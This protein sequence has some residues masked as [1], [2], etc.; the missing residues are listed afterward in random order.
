MTTKTTT[1]PNAAD[2]L[3]E[4]LTLAVIDAIEADPM[5]WS[6]TWTTQIGADGLPYNATTGTA[7]RGGNVLWLLVTAADR[8]YGSNAWATYKQWKAAGAQ[9]RRGEKATGC[10]FWKR[11]EREDPDTGE[12]RATMFARTFSVFNLARVEV[13]DPDAFAKRAKIAAAIDPDEIGPDSASAI[14]AWLAAVPA[15]YAV[16]EPAYSPDLDVVYMPPAG[17]FDAPE[18]HAGT[19]AHE[20]SHWTGHASRLNRPRHERWGDDAYA[21][22]ELIAEMSAAFICATHGIDHVTRP[23]HLAYLQAWARRFRDDPQAIWSAATKASAAFE[24]LADAVEARRAERT[25]V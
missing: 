4:S 3:R 13:T 12:T 10:L 14:G 7:Y 6:K 1:K 9:V 24:F 16:G 23:D 20:L 15:A 8:G 11:T 25:T 5:H 18:H 17:A 22:E 21:F 2:A 19:L